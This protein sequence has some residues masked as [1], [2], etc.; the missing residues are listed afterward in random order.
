MAL[1]VFSTLDD[2]I[3]CS[4]DEL[5]RSI[6]N[7]PYNTLIEYILYLR[8]KLGERDGLN[9]LGCQ[10]PADHH[11]KVPDFTPTKLRTGF[12][13]HATFLYRAGTNDFSF[14]LMKDKQFYLFHVSLRQGEGQVVMN[15]RDGAWGKEVRAMLP[16]LRDNKL[17]A[18]NIKCCE[19]EF[20]VQIAG[21]WLETTFPYRYP[22]SDVAEVKLIHGSEGNMWTSLSVVQAPLTPL[23][24]ALDTTYPVK[25]RPGTTIHAMFLYQEGSGKFNLNLM[26]NFPEEKFFILHADI[27]PSQEKIILNTNPNDHWEAEERYLLGVQLKPGEIHPFR[28]ECGVE[29]FRIVIGDNDELTRKFRYR[30]PLDDVSEVMLSHGSMGN[31]WVSLCTSVSGR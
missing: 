14:N 9:E 1:R 27:R 4:E 7:V 29:E 18:V 30:Y 20:K 31:K 3:A 21:K 17:H 24:P 6:G 12:E 11:Q 16:T 13:V 8:E 19:E 15:S 22:L 28:V 5:K 25:I 10:D 26:K 2:L 23:L